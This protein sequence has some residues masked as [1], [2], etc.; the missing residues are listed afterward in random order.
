MAV[1]STSTCSR[2]L[3]ASTSTWTRST[4]AV[5]DFE[6]YALWCCWA[7]ILIY[8]LMLELFPGLPLRPGVKLPTMPAEDNVPTWDGDPASFEAFV[9]AC[10]WYASSLK[11]SERKLAASRVWQRLRG[12]AKS[13]VKRL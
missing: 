8:L 4:A 10:K 5:V 9:T 1:A 11:E 7:Y 12:A 2:W 13:V 3:V 6:R